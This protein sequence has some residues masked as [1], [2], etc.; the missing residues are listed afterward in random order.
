[1]SIT[2]NITP[3]LETRVRQAAAKAGVE[4]DTYIADILEQYLHV[5][6]AGSKATGLSKTETALLQQ[7][8][9]GLSQ[10]TWRRYHELIEKRRAETLT[11]DEQ[12]ALIEI[13]DEIERANARR[14]SA[15]VELAQYRQT[16][17]DALMD[18][19]GIKAPTYE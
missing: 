8:N 7:I 6:Q 5:Q 4:P 2:L 13:T 10:E 1:M 3:D 9:L 12:K 14:I 19:L 16:S 18:K 15:L 17:L 11:P